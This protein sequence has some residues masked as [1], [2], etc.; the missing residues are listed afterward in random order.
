MGIFKKKATKENVV[1]ATAPE[2]PETQAEAMYTQA[3]NQPTPT[4]T[5]EPV[6]QVQ[7]PVPQVTQQVAQPTPEPQPEVRQI[8]VIMSEA[9]KWNMVIENNMMLKHI[10]SKIEDA[11]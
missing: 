4:A 8:P 10:V 2:V 3:M 1:M 9:D 11:E 5:Q 6:V 7:Q